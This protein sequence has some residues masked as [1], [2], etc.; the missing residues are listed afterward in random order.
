MKEDVFF[1]TISHGHRPLVMW[2]LT[3]GY[4]VSVFNFTFNLKSISWLRNLIDQGKV[5]RLQLQHLSDTVDL[6]ME[7]TEWLYPQLSS[8]KLV[9]CLYDLCGK[10]E[11]EMVFKHGILSSVYRY[12]SIRVFLKDY[13][14]KS[15]PGRSVMLIPDSFSYW[16]GL[17]PNWT[18]QHLGPLHDVKIPWWARTW[19]QAVGLQKKAVENFKYCLASS[20]DLACIWLGRRLN[21]SDERNG[22][23]EYDNI[24][25]IDQ[26]FQVQFQGRRKFDFL[27]DN[28]NLTME[29]TAFLVSRSATGQW[30]DEARRAGYHI[31]DRARFADERN[32][33]GHLRSPSRK[34]DLGKAAKAVA[35]GA[36]R[37][38]APHWLLQT[39]A[40]GISTYINEG[41]ILERVGF[42]NY[43]YTNQ[44]GAKQRWRNI[45]L[46][47]EGRQSWY[48]ALAIGGGYIYEDGDGNCRL[49]RLW[50]YQ[51]PDHFVLQGPQMVD[52]QKKH[53]QKVREYHD[54]GN[55]LSELISIPSTATSGDEELDHWFAG[56]AREG[57][58]IAWFDTSFV[59]CAGSYS[60]YTEAIAWY[61][62]IQRL[63]REE[64]A[65]WAVIKPSKSKGYF[66]DP[67]QEWSHPLGATLMGK[68]DELKRHPRV[69]FADRKVDPAT[70]IALSDLNVTFCF[71][72]CTAEALGAG[73]RAIWYEPGERW[74]HTLYGRDPM[75]VA[76]GY[77]ELRDLTNKLLYDVD[78]EEY[79]RY[80]QERVR[81]LVESFLD[82]KGL[83]RFRELLHKAAHNSGKGPLGGGP[84]VERVPAH[85]LR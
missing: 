27:I 59:E 45:M 17:L 77:E 5:E 52:Y 70:V 43:I 7:A 81:G 54:V 19:S 56:P 35:Q 48:F 73:K 38:K 28:Q 16:D 82:G 78:D 61:A 64:E 47:R 6:A 80:L 42:A 26:P 67:K 24:Y 22:T 69:Y 36:A 55:I 10:D 65:M 9:R 83:S 40:V 23:L 49:H 71:S 15:G 72:S 46:R 30:M 44:D 1:E 2:Y 63:L 84:M 21:R 8:D 74:R 85:K 13:L 25:A 18:N 51:N 12:L 11:S 60:S 14:E 75:L 50:M 37:L 62:D 66:I 34:A 79:Q 57:K 4:R 68:W 20:M 29:N 3:R 33:L 58:I 32:P 76:H 31:L 53:H 41:C 39:A